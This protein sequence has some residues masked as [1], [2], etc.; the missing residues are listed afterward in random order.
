MERM[1]QKLNYR[2]LPGK[3]VA[4]SFN[5]S[6]LWQAPD[7]LL[8][9][10][11]RGYAEEYKRFYYGD[12]QAIVLRRTNFANLISGILAV[13]AAFPVL[14]FLAGIV[15]HWGK[16]ALIAWGTIAGFLLLLIV[17]NL[18]KGPTCRVEIQTA[19]QK[20]KLTSLSRLATAHKTIARILPA[21]EAAQS[22]L[23][24]EQPQAEAQ[25]G[26]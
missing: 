9:V 24:R 17:I 26:T 3:S 15:R 19:V 4:F 22:I 6:S 11:N 18:L 10:K 25:T 16:A 23:D 20:E 12:I 5:R 14:L 1:E 7:H 21:I 13:F 8:L 2:R